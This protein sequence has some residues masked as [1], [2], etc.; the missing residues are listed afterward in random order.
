MCPWARETKASPWVLSCKEPES[1]TM[2]C[3]IP[4]LA[5]ARFPCYLAEIL[6]LNDISPGFRRFL[7]ETRE[8]GINPSHPGMWAGI[9][10]GQENNFKYHVYLWGFCLYPPK[11]KCLNLDLNP[12][13]IW[14]R[15]PT[16]NR[17]TITL[18]FHVHQWAF[19]ASSGQ[20]QLPRSVQ[21]PMKEILTS[22]ESSYKHICKTKRKSTC[23]RGYNRYLNT[24]GQSDQL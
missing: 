8:Q 22:P 19:S 17:W 4:A 24:Y 10:S 13:H 21:L 15:K 11:Q 18:F 1:P 2:W 20:Y 3:S 6:N 14:F 16:W 12:L 7:K 9:I 23:C 5:L